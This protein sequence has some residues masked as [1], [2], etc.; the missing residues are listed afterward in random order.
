MLSSSSKKAKVGKLR[1]NQQWMFHY[2]ILFEMM[3]VMNEFSSFN[4]V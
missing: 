1:P 2:F 4:L 3:Q